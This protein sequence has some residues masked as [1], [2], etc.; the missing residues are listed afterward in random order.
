ML[1]GIIG[2]MNNNQAPVF[3]W[4]RY[5]WM[6]ALA[7]LLI[8]IL[9]LGVRPVMIPDEVRYAE[10]PREMMVSG[11]W[12]SPHLNGLRYFEKPVL[13]Y[14]VTGISMQLFGDN[15]FAM[16]L[17]SALSAGLSAL[18]IFLLLRHVTRRAETALLATMIY[19]S[20]LGVYLIGTINI[21]DSVFSFLLTAGFVSFYYSHI[22]SDP[23]KRLIQL[24]LLGV[25]CGGAFL[26]KGFLAFVLLAAVIVPYVVWQG[27]WPELF[28]RGWVALLVA[29]LVVAPWAI[30]VHIDEPEYWHYFFWEEHIRRFASD[31]AQHGEPFWFYLMY[32]PLLVMPWIMH[33]PLSI[34][35][36]MAS[37]KD[38][39]LIRF[40]LLWFLMPFI[41]FSMANGKLP[42][43]VLPCLAPLAVLL[44]MGFESYFDN[45]KIPGFKLA[46]AFT[47]ILFFIF[48]VAL[49]LLQAGVVGK[50]VWYEGEG[51]K[52][53]SLA[54]A[55]V[56][57]AVLV[58][59]SMRKQSSNRRLTL[60]ALSVSALMLVMTFAL[61]QRT[62]ESK[63]PGNFLLEHAD[64]VT[65]DTIIF[66][67]D[68]M[69]HAVNWY[70]RRTDV[71]MTAAGESKHGLSFK[72]SSHRLLSGNDLKA[73]IYAHLNKDKMVIIHHSD[74]DAFMQSIMPS[75]AQESRW[76]NFVLWYIPMNPQE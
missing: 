38:A 47:A 46:S 26:S 28:T 22:E 4:K 52:W 3:N 69:I 11:D 29:L 21:L 42:T 34:K 2:A 13:G 48:A 9:P 66:S 62:E 40:C 64:M 37:D 74:A 58:I 10:I 43:Y 72:D 14:W 39:G 5:A 53:M 67:D 51:W 27:R 7:Y 30:M 44:A 68:I 41:F 50:T 71:Y 61:P 49:V 73:F 70:Y 75:Q 15:A 18:A 25:F 33:I 56:F 8:Y 36:M 54:L 63:A 45:K 76:G 1:A 57:G 65:P 35:G 12:V 6:L 31:D 23:K 32:L 20:M 17:P 55:F 59:L 60:L 24:I 16:R 19:L